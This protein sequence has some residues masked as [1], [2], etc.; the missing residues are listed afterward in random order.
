M[1][2]L[3]ETLTSPL[4]RMSFMNSMDTV[5]LLC[6]GKK[7]LSPRGLGLDICIHT[8]LGRIRSHIKFASIRIGDDVL[9]RIESNPNLGNVDPIHR[10][11]FESSRV[12][13]MPYGG[14][15]PVTLKARDEVDR[16]SKH[17]QAKIIVQIHRG[18]V[19]IKFQGDGGLFHSSVSA[20]KGLSRWQHIGP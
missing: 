8:K 15:F 13:S 12:N 11:S 6:S 18:F 20:L 4:G 14:G 17:S 5:I 19:R 2:T 16:V 10:L 9:H 3:V 7:C 1:A